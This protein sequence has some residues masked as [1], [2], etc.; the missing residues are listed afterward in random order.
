MA[1]DWSIAAVAEEESAIADAIIEL[2][3]DYNQQFIGRAPYD[4]FRLA[5][6][7]REGRLIGGLLGE[8][9]SYWLHV[10]ILVV[11]E[12]Y[13]RSGLGSAL[14]ADAERVAREKNYRGIFLDTF[15]FQAPRFYEKLGFTRFGS[16]R[17]YCDGYDRHFYEKRL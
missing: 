2:L 3:K 7:D 5:A 4:L 9:R 8:W 10:D 1:G 6:H 11:T 12:P 14:M 13:R 16:I 15:E 17:N